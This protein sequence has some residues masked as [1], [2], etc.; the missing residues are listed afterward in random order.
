MV[1]KIKQTLWRWRGVLIAVPSVTGVV[2]ALRLVGL[3]QLLE[4]NAYDQLFLLRP[5]EPVDE[6]ILVVTID[7]PDIQALKQYPMNDATLTRI[8][9]NIKQHRPSAIGLDIYRDLVYEPGHADLVKVFES[10]PNLIGVQKVSKSVDSS[11]VAPPPALK[12]LDQVGANDLPLDRDGRIRRGLLSA[13][14]PNGDPIFSFA[15][16]LAYRYFSQHGVDSNLT[17]DER[18]FAGP[19]IFQPFS[20]NDG[21]Y[22]RENAKG[23]QLL[24]NYRGEIK[25]FRTVGVMAVLRNEV[26][27]EL[28]R[29]RI[30]LIG[31]IAESD[32]DLFYT[33][34]ST[35]LLGTPKR[36]P[37]VI[38]H[39]NLISTILSAAMNDRELIQ[40]WP[41]WAEWLWIFGWTAIG[42][43]SCWVKRPAEQKHQF[44]FLRR[45]RLLLA[46][47]CLATSVYGAFLAGWWIPAVPAFLGLAGASFLVVGYLA[48]NAEEMRKTFGRYLTDE[49]VANL[50]ETP[51]G[52]KLGGERRKV[53]VL[54]SDLRGFSA[55]SESLPPE[56]VVTMLNLYLGVMTDV[57]DRYK[58]TINEFMGDGVV[59]M[60]GAPINRPDD[61]QRAI[62]C[63]IAMQQAMTNVNEQNHQLGL[64]TIEMGIGLN[65]GEVVVGNIGSQKRAKYT[66]IGNHVNLA[67]RIESY[68]V[69]GQI[70]ISEATLKE[71]HCEVQID[72]QLQVEPKGIREPI[73]LYD[74]GGIGG[75]FDLFLPKPGDAL[76]HLNPALVVEYTILEGKHAIGNLFQGTFT[77]LSESSA[78]L[79]TD[80][81]IDVLT[82]LKLRFLTGPER[83][84]VSEDVYAKV[85]RKLDHSTHCFLVRFTAT[86][87]SVTTLIQTL[88]NQN[89]ERSSIETPVSEPQSS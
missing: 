23:Y 69:G 68:T 26:P 53:T 48:H 54:M 33:P 14:D 25:D 8:L 56:T 10:T 3:L 44:L 72:G 16:K 2:I 78:E 37:G 80:H 87:P 38:I 59:I 17:E 76:L 81:H 13:N 82:N 21:G 32:K 84:Q 6:R 31:N 4:L 19:A 61:A 15:F 66:V 9:Q 45:W 29:D 18:I 28:I 5:R 35:Q 12:K 41:E 7:E 46:S 62:A 67:A 65:T 83:S 1:P 55:L 39:A 86:P 11:P 47:G 24:L 27:P 71:A 49:V 52:L 74:V 40:T 88:L 85:T 30:V 75:P 20:G 57:V 73:M 50:L 77:R 63:A 64:P 22:V 51:G 42:G 70:L 36:T 43:I 89:L 79:Q 34:Y 58:G 60:F